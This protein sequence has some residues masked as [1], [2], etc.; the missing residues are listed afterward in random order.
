MCC[1]QRKKTDIDEQ[2]KMLCE[3]WDEEQIEIKP[4]S[5]LYHLE[6][7]SVGSPMVESLTSYIMR[8]ATEHSVSTSRLIVS[9][10]IPLLFS[11]HFYRKQQAANKHMNPF[12]QASACLNATSVLARSVV[13]AVEQLTLHS[14]L[15]FLTMLTFEDILSPKSLNRRMRA[16]CPECYEEWEETNQIVYEPLLWSLETVCW[17][18]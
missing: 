8:L 17:C 6:P 3:L 12:W 13:Q 4:H 10:I 18:S 7:I 9:E 1:I 14:D 11:S 2:V 15:R 5:R 16:W